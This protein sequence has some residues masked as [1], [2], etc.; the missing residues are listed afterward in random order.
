MLP[1]DVIEG[2]EREAFSDI[3]RIIMLCHYLLLLLL[4]ASMQFHRFYLRFFL[5]SS[6]HINRVD[7]A[8]E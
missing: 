4:T 8:V 6:Y 3:G 5:E 1:E 7:N 2:N